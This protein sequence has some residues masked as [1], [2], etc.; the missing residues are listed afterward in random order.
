M[1]EIICLIFGHLIYT[2]PTG[3]YDC[4]D[5]AWSCKYC[6]KDLTCQDQWFGFEFNNKITKWFLDRENSKLKLK[7]I[8][9]PF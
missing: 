9:F 7:D 3:S 6:D 8:D 4:P 2:H 5:Q 1:K